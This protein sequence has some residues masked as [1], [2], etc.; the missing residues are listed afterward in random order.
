MAS[1]LMRWYCLSMP[2][3]FPL[4]NIPIPADRWP[5]PAPELARLH[6]KRR[7]YARSIAAREAERVAAGDGRSEWRDDAE[8]D[9]RYWDSALVKALAECT[10]EELAELLIQSANDG[11]LAQAVVLEFGRRTERESSDRK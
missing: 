11:A 1:S 9:A 5:L 6:A 3:S 10:D 8:R 7:A 4:A 2:P